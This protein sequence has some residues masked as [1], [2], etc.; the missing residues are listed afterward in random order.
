M[1]AAMGGTQID[2]EKIIILIEANHRNA[3]LVFGN[4]KPLGVPGNPKP[5]GVPGNPKPLGVP[6]SGVSM[7]GYSILGSILGSP[8]ILV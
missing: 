7:K 8:F 2:L 5:L 6:F 4:P 3:S 1:V